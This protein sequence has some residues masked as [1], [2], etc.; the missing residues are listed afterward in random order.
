MPPLLTVLA[1]TRSPVGDIP[2]PDTLTVDKLKEWFNTW[3]KTFDP[4]LL[5]VYPEKPIYIYYIDWKVPGQPAPNADVIAV[6][7]KGQ[8]SL[9]SNHPRWIT[10]FYIDN[11]SVP[12]M[13]GLLEICAYMPDMAG[14]EDSGNCA[15][16]AL[17]MGFSVKVKNQNGEVSDATLPFPVWLPPPLVGEP[18]WPDIVTIGDPD[19]PNIP[20]DNRTTNYLGKVANPDSLSDVDARFGQ[21]RWYSIEKWDLTDLKEK[22]TDFFKIDKLTKID[23][24]LALSVPINI[25]DKLGDIRRAGTWLIPDKVKIPV[26]W[27][28]DW[29]KFEIPRDSSLPNNPEKPGFVII[30]RDD[31][32]SRV[33]SFVDVENYVIEKLLTWASQLWSQ[34]VNTQRVTFPIPIP[35]GD[36]I[37]VG[38]ER[39]AG[40]A[41]E[42]LGTLIGNSMSVQFAFKIVDEQG[43]PGQ[44]DLHDEQGNKIIMGAYQ[45]G[46]E[47][48]KIGL[49]GKEVAFKCRPVC[50]STPLDPEKDSEKTGA[51]S[52]QLCV[53]IRIIN[54]TIKLLNREHKNINIEQELNLGLPVIFH[55]E[56]LVIP[57]LVI[58]FFHKIQVGNDAY[59][60]ML[61]NGT[62]LFKDDKG[63]DA[64][65]H[66]DAYTS[67][68]FNDIRLKITTELGR[69]G[70]LLNLVQDFFPTPGLDLITTAAAAGYAIG[71]C[72]IDS[73]GSV[74]DLHQWVYNKRDQISGGDQ[75][76]FQELSAVV[77]IG[78]PKSISH[79]EIQCFEFLKFNQMN[80]KEQKYGKML[81]LAMPDNQFIAAIPAFTDLSTGS[82]D[83]NVDLPE[84][85]T[86][87]GSFTIFDNM[88]TSIKFETK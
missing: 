68:Q 38:V 15:L 43:G 50:R 26:F 54:G 60:V 28:D 61:P 66:L 86:S 42:M 32:P 19:K 11:A 85:S 16:N 12:I 71:T 80:P 17:M 64:E 88:I 22:V 18:V 9:T 47:P 56:P 62:G 82:K 30:W 6:D 31:I 37:K 81:S 40:E 49:S 69:I 14:L 87:P 45:E 79:T 75:T 41:N 13:V 78:A 34:T 3:I 7:I 72:V 8:P 20:P 73:K 77:M 63:N 84:Y 59:L 29:V 55:P 65:V 46:F 2:N 83:F 48:N 24:Q 23:T 67:N 52:L 53:K 35:L 74:E 4:A 27:D 57:T 1:I 21:V 58:F 70:S 76:F 39:L 5:G 10:D 33:I 51:F 25:S 36:V 44:T